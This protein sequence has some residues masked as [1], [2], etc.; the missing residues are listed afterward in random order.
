M[1][2]VDVRPQD[3]RDEW[4]IHGSYHVDAY[5]ALNKGDQDIFDNLPVSKEIAIVTVSAAG[6]TSQIAAL[7]K[8]SKYEGIDPA[9]LEAGAN[10]CTIS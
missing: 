4:N 2:I 9:D 10:R 1:A 7:N 3:Q 6:R 5:E 8:T